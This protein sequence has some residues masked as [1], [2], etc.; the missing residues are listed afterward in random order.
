MGTF[1]VDRLPRYAGFH[2]GTS[3]GQ[4]RIVSEK[5]D[6]QRPPQNILTEVRYED[7]PT[8]GDR[9]SRSAYVTRGV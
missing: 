7:I 3:V 8:H 2:V 9:G 5:R 6:L 4:H 1:R